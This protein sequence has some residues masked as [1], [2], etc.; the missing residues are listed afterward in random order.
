MKKIPRNNVEKRQQDRLE[1]VT[2]CGNYTDAVEQFWSADNK[3]AKAQAAEKVASLG[4][5]LI[6]KQNELGL[7]MR[8]TKGIRHRVL[9]AQHWLNDNPVSD[10]NSVDKSIPGWAA[11]VMSG[12]PSAKYTKKS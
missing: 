6:A 4:E 12:N 8:P 5:Q 3:V 11:F 1:A 2:I 10:T 7:Q 9:T